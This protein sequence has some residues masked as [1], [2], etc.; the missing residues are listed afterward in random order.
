LLGCPLEAISKV[1]PENFATQ[2]GDTNAREYAKYLMRAKLAAL[3]FKS[4]F[5]IF[6]SFV[7]SNLTVAM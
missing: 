1:I 7:L 3:N 4:I 6:T 5:F 2:F